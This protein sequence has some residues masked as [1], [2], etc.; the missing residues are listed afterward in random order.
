MIIKICLWLNQAMQPG[1]NTKIKSRHLHMSINALHLPL[2][3]TMRKKDLPL[4]ITSSTARCS[5]IGPI[6]VSALLEL[7]LAGKMFL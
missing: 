3:E 4:F 2:T 5:A 1:I 7:L 6:Y